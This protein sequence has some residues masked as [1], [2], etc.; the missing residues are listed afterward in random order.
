[1]EYLEIRACQLTPT[2][3]IQLAN[4][5]K[6][7]S[8]KSVIASHNLCGDL[9]I[10]KIAEVLEGSTKLE[11]LDLTDNEITDAGGEILAGSLAKNSCLKRLYLCDNKIGNGTAFHLQ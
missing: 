2:M 6:I 11:A 4:G 7:S 3:F 5:L 10:P 8:I 1:V 9:P